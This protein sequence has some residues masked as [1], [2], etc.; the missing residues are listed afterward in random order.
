MKVRD[1]MLALLEYDLDD[2]IVIEHL[3][4]NIDIDVVYEY[5]GDVLI[6]TDG[7]TR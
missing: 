2:N 4:Q 7:E 5:R 3:D 1:L 6:C